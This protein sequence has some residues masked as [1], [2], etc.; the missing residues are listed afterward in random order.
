MQACSYRPSVGEHWILWT[1]A[2]MSA[3]YER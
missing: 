2:A 1:A 3:G